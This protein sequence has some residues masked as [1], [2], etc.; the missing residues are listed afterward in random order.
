MWGNRIGDEGATAFAEAL[1]NHP[2]L[3][4]LRYCCLLGPAVPGVQPGHSVC[5]LLCQGSSQGEGVG[6]PNGEGM[7]VCV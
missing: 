1:R 5:L 6:L 2:S 7:C 4:N 3:T